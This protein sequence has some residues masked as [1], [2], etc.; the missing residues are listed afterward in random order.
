MISSEP[1]NINCSPEL[2]ARF[3]KPVL[4]IKL[5]P[6]TEKGINLKNYPG[7]RDYQDESLHNQEKEEQGHSQ[8]RR[9]GNSI[10]PKTNRKNSGDEKRAK[11]QEIK[12]K[13]GNERRGCRLEG[14]AEAT[15]EEINIG[16][17]TQASRKQI[18]QGI[19]NK[20]DEKNSRPAHPGWLK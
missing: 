10:N 20:G 16:K 8:N 4:I 19:L 12:Q 5:K 7:Q 1:E 2:F 9:R 6:E 3:L 14:Q 11:G 15:I 18:D 17:R 13:G